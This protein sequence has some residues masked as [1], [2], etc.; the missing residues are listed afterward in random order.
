[1]LDQ[2]TCQTIRDLGFS[3]IPLCQDAD[4]R[5]VV[6]IFLTKSLVSY[7]ECGETIM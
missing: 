6:A 1:V 3:R 4:D 2:K 5:T 7:D